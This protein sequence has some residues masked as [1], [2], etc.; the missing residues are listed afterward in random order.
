M[1]R[2]ETVAFATL[3]V[4]AL[5]VIGALFF[6]FLA[7]ERPRAPRTGRGVGDRLR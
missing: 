6:A 4:I 2:I 5:V 1:N 7:S 3:V